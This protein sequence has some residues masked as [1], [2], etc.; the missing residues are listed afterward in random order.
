MLAWLLNH[1]YWCKVASR[2]L[3]SPHSELIRTP[4]IS[5]VPWVSVNPGAPHFSHQFC[6]PPKSAFLWFSAGPTSQLCLGVYAGYWKVLNEPVPPPIMAQVKRAGLGRPWQGPWLTTPDLKM[7]LLGVLEQGKASVKPG[8][9][10]AA[11]EVP[12]L[13]LKIHHCCQQP[14]SE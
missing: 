11:P 6:L 9:P 7:C 10:K 13:G 14:F 12:M 4:H 1:S 8:S 2:P 3:N 5:L